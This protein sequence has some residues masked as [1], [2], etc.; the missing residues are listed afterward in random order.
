MLLHLNMWTSPVGLGKCEIAA[1]CLSTGKRH[2]MQ[3]K[4]FL[5]ALGLAD[6]FGFKTY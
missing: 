4:L 1:E 2:H 3:V 6:L 5:R